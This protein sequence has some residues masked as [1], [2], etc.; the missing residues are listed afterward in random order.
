MTA[1]GMRPLEGRNALVLGAELPAGKHAASALARAGANVAAVTITEDVQAEFA[2]NSVANELWA[3]GRQGIALTSDGNETAVREAIADATVEL[4]PIRIL[5]WHAPSPL[6]AEALSG[7][8]SDPAVV[9]LIAA[10]APPEDARALL[11]WTRELSGSGLRANAIIA[12]QEL[13]AAAGPALKQHHAPRGALDLPAAVVYLTS[14]D[15]AAVE[16]AFIV[17]AP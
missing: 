14:D 1:A 9:V 11:A 12:S 6:P 10:D 5:V 3:L 2:A 8:R 4:G 17:A 15:S 7:L 13:A 16:G